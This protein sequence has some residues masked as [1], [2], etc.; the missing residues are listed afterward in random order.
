M[1]L[2]LERLSSTWSDAED[3]NITGREKHPNIESSEESGSA[4]TV[5]TWTGLQCSY[6]SSQSCA[7]KK[8]AEHWNAEL[9]LGVGL[10]DMRRGINIEVR[11]K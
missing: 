1:Q 3:K 7:I 10:W 8:V 2:R 6:R 5:L 11:Q 9:A 4:K